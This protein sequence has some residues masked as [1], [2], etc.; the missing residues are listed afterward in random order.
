VEL[1]AEPERLSLLPGPTLELE[2]GDRVTV[3]ISGRSF[4]SREGPSTTT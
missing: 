4:F 1:T 2:E 3:R